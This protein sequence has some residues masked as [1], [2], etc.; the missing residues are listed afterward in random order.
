[1]NL[2]QQIAAS[3]TVMATCMILH[4]LIANAKHIINELTLKGETAK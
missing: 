2:I 1:M 4:V 3:I